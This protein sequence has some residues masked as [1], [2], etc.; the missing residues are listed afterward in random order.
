MNKNNNTLSI[1]RNHRESFEIYQNNKEIYLIQIKYF[2]LRKTN[3]KKSSINFK[4]FR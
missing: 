1:Q 4:V 3:Y 2:K